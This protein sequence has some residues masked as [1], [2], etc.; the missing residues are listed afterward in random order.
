MDEKRKMEG[1]GGT[2]VRYGVGL[3]FFTNC[4]QL[5]HSM[6][7][8]SKFIYFC[9]ETVSIGADK[10]LQTDGGVRAKISIKILDYFL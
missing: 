9:C 6:T 8:E 10:L 1:V 2:H 7:C 5:V 3:L 4:F